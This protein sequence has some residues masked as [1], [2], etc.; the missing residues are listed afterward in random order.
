MEC[1]V[2]KNGKASISE[3]YD[4]AFDVISVLEKETVSE[5]LGSRSLSSDRKKLRRLLRTLRERVEVEQRASEDFMRVASNLNNNLL[6]MII[7]MIARDCIKHADLISI[8]AQ[9]IESEK[10]VEIDLIDRQLLSKLLAQE[11]K[12][13]VHGLDDV[14]DLIEH[15][16]LKIIIDYVESDERKHEKTLKSLLEYISSLGEAKEKSQSK[17]RRSSLPPQPHSAR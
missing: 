12:Y 11:E 1:I 4:L 3:L 13:H 2:D 6:R 17:E 14:R 15:P 8:A 16:L 10:E 5:D 7:R 9:I